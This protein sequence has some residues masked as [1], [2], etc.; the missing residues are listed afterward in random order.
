MKLNELED[1]FPEIFIYNK[2]DLFKKY[3]EIPI[4]EKRRL[5][6]W[7]LKSGYHFVSQNFLG[8]NVFW[9]NRY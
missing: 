5:V 7:S 1:L 2:K 3:I 9:Q 8:R 6:K 4:L